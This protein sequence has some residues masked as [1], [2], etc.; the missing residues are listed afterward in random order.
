MG[1]RPTTAGDE[2]V[3]EF[4]FQRTDF[5]QA[6]QVPLGFAEF[7]FQKRLDEIPGHLRPHRPSAH[8][9][10]IHVVVFHALPGREVIVDQ[11]R[12]NAPD[13]IGA[14]RGPPLPQRRR[15]QPSRDDRLR[16]RHDKI[17]VIIGRIHGIRPEIDDF[18]PGF[19]K[20]AQQLFLQTKPPMISGNSYTHTFSFPQLLESVHK[21]MVSKKVVIPAKAGIQCFRDLLDAG[22][23]PA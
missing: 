19:A 4:C 10:N 3:W 7:G 23:S 9:Q 16:E 17:G 12:A 18:V 11:R 5:A 6:A 20:F 8:A 22:S 21:L 1:P 14:D 15:I 13:F 2:V